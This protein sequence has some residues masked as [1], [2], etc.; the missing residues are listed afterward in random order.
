MV[1]SLLLYLPDISKPLGRRRRCSGV[2]VFSVVSTGVVG[3]F[4]EPLLNISRV[5]RIHLPCQC[6]NLLFVDGIVE[7]TESGLCSDRGSG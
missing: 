6:E 3:S 1:E 7:Q 4:L 5:F 2:V